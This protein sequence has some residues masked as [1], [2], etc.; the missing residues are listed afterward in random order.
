MNSSAPVKF[1][2]ERRVCSVSPSSGVMPRG[3]ALTGTGGVATTT[4]SGFGGGGTTVL[5]PLR[6]PI[7]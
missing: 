2:D 5:E 1:L 6:W 4:G 7:M 3:S